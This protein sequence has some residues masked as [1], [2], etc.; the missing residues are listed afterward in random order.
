M[1]NKEFGIGR[2]EQG[3]MVFSAMA[4]VAQARGSGILDDQ[5]TLQAMAEIGVP[6]AEPQIIASIEDA[7][8]QLAKAFGTTPEEAMRILAG[9]AILGLGKKEK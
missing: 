9:R 5:A 8:Q 4:D 7:A 2:K 3:E 1:A 6:H